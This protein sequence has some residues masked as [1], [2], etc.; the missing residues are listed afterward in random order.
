MRF[1]R[2]ELLSGSAAIAAY[3]SLPAYAQFNGCPTGFCSGVSSGPTVSMGFANGVYSGGTLANLISTTNSGGY[4]TNADGSLTSFAA[5]TPRIGSGTGLLVEE[6]RTNLTT[7]SQNLAGTGRS[8][9]N[10]STLQTQGIAPDNTNTANTL[11]DNGTSGRHI[12]FESVLPGSSA[13]YV[14]S[15]FLKAGTL[16]YA[17]VQM[18]I[19]SGAAYGVVFDLQAGTTTD[20]KTL[21][22]PTLT[23][24]TITPYVNGWYRCTVTLG[25][26]ASTTLFSTIATSNS[27]TPT[28]DANGNPTYSG[29]S[30]NLFVWQDDW[31]AGATFPTSPI[32]TTTTSVTRNADN[33]QAA[34]ALATTL[35]ASTGTIVIKTNNSIQSALATLVDANGTVFLGKTAGN[36]GTTAIGATLSTA[37]TGTWTGANDL[38]LAWDASGGAIQLNGGTIVTDAIARTPSATFH[39]GSTSG[40]SAFLNGYITQLS[41]YNT[42]QASPQ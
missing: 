13:Q 21:L 37:N 34:G 39:L 22:S 36:I 32:P 20:T 38:G 4:A 31:N 14:Y 19:A 33:V 28:Y 27:A 10:S 41:A 30:Q 23:S 35:A 7:S 3:E 1:S 24:N 2:R 25:A 42:K 40:S 12:T 8:V 29:A 9:S 26:T 16:R 11:I 18:A 5:N 15:V 17:Q 6:A